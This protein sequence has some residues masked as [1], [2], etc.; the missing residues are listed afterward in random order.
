MVESCQMKK[1]QVLT[2]W[3]K[4]T[5]NDNELSMKKIWRKCVI[6]KINNNH[7]YKMISG[8]NIEE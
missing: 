5:D 4:F 7:N 6:V 1:F 8:K 2:N 3:I